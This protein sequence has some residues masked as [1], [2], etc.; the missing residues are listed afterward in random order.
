MGLYQTR[1]ILSTQQRKKM[2]KLRNN[3]RAGGL[4]QEVECLPSKCEAL[5]SKP[6][7]PKKMMLKMK[8]KMKT[9]EEGEENKEEGE[10]EEEKIEKKKKEEEEEEEEKENHRVGKIFTN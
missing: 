5:S 7:P 6:V 10:K 1:K 4:D 3:Y 9:K 8:E 2:M